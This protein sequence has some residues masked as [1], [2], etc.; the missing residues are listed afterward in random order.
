MGVGRI[1]PEGGTGGGFQYFSRRPKVV[2][3]VFPTSNKENN[4]ILLKFSNS[5][6]QGRPR[7]SSDA[8]DTGCLV[9]IGRTRA[10]A[11]WAP[12]NS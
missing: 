12:K 9:L 10:K 4:L 5:R 1:C 6:G 11:G 8:H 7:P 2:K 3:F